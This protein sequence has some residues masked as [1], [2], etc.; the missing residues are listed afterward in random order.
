MNQRILP[1]DQ[2]KQIYNDL[3]AHYDRSLWL[4]SLLGFRIKT[5][6]REAIEQLNLQPGDT[7]VDLGCGT[8]LN[9]G[10]LQ[11][12]VGP[13]GKIIGVDL[14]DSMLAQARK[15]VEKAGWNNVVL[16]QADFESFSPPAGTDGILSTMALT[17]SA[18]YDEVIRRLANE[19]EPGKR[20]AIF[21]L[22][23]P[24]R[25]PDWLVQMMVFLLRSY[26][27]RPGH[28]RRTPWRSIQAYF[29]DTVYCEFYAGAVY[30]AAGTSVPDA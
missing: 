4:F 2:I 13:E 7:V 14:S 17:M 28:T 21:E 15:R 23:K 20:M 3:A 30:V 10:L 1:L 24:G 16:K 26:G 6:R 12:K 5:Y 9:F 22:K 29:M 19:L 25:W 27:T 11:E 8:G 18:D